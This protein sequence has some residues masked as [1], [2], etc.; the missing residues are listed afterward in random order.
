MTQY[1]IAL[2]RIGLDREWHELCLLLLVELGD[3]RR[4]SCTIE[5]EQT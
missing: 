4:V 1:R 5:T 3:V 2:G